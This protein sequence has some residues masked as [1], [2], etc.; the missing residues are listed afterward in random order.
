MPIPPPLQRKEDRLAFQKVFFPGEGTLLLQRTMTKA[1]EEE[2][3]IPKPAFLARKNDP[4]K[5][6]IASLLC[7]R[8]RN[9]RFGD[10]QTG[11]QNFITAKQTYF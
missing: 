11:G 6:H 8:R 1:K 2:E 4:G 7:M 9:A 10:M 3:K 5:A